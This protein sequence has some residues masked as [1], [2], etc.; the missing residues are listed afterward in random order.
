MLPTA[1]NTVGH[2]YG[3]HFPNLLAGYYWYLQNGLWTT[4]WFSPALCGGFPFFADPNV[5]YY[6]ATQLFVVAV[7]PIR[8]VQLTFVLFAL[9]AMAGTFVLM[10]RSFQASPISRDQTRRQ[11]RRRVS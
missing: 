11:G 3:V 5:L 2:D 1:H 6:S 8:A 9:I 10:R 4:P 7:S